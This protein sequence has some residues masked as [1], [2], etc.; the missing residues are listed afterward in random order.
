MECWRYP[1]KI[2]W[3]LSSTYQL[4]H[5]CFACQKSKLWKADKT[6]FIEGY[7]AVRKDWNNI[8]RGGLLFFIR[9]GIFFEKLHSFE[10]AGMEIFSI[11]LKTTESTWLGLYNV[12]LPNITTQQNF[13]D[14]SLINP[15]PT[16]IILG[17]FNRRS[18]LW[19]PLQPPDS[20]GDKILD[21]IIDNDLYI[22]NDGSATQTSCV[23]SN[24]RL[25]TSHSLAAIGQP[26][27]LGN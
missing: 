11:C 10:E 9:T 4:W 27:H 1:P 26:R 22:L 15:I 24:D 12:Y 16:L 8:L 21:W 2:S 13:F 20:R 5:W 6:P 3:T 23:T 19:D 14:P 18:Q 7:A 17:D 25:L